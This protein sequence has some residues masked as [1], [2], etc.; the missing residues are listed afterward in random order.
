MIGVDT[1][2]LVRY[3]AQ[4]EPNQARVAAKLFASL[5]PS[6]PAFVSHVVLAE[7]VWVLESC[8]AA[9]SSKIGEVVATLLRTDAIRVERA[10]MVWQALRRFL[11]TQG[12]FSDA[13]IAE[14]AQAAGCERIFSF[15]RG[16]VTRSGMTLLR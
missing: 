12:D 13:L 9:D 2:V 15:D 1:N 16:A 6:S 5:S 10:D 4:D 8:Y 11:A 3:L 14:L 7:T